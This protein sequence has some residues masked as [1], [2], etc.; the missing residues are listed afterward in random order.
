MGNQPSSPTPA[1]PSAS[2]PS[3]PPLPP[4]CDL[5]CQKEKQLVLL[6]QN[7]DAANKQSDPEG[8][9]KAR[10]AYFTLL[11]GPG[12]LAQE[13]QRIAKQEVEPTTLNDTQR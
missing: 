8:Y 5:Q 10:I 9:E 11:N 13:K 6:K 7:L 3:I 2:P 1:P 4:P 12:W